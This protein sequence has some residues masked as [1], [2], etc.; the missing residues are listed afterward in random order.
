MISVGVTA[1]MLAVECLEVG[2]NTTCMYTGLGYSSPILSS[3]IGDLTP[4]FTF[5][6]AKLSRSESLLCFLILQISENLVISE[7]ALTVTLY[8]GP[9]ILITSSRSTDSHK[10][11]QLL[12]TNWVIGGLLLTVAYF[13]LSLL[14][15]VQAVFAV[16]LRSL[17]HTLACHNSQEETCTRS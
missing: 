13:F 10:R 15:I 6:L 9:A 17:V 7:G 11:L 1:V 12:Q 14:Y 16:A 4:A 5:I 8:K 2:L 3:A